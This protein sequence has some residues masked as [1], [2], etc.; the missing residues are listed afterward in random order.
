MILIKLHCILLQASGAQFMWCC[1]SGAVQ[2]A[3]DGVVKALS[4]E[5]LT[6]NICVNCT[7]ITPWCAEFRIRDV[8]VLVC[9][10]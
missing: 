9:R 5:V 10:Y 1:Q 3:P 6:R 8:A 7:T 2:R 4:S